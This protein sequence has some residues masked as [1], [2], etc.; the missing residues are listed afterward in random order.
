MKKVKIYA[1]VS[2]RGH[3]IS[4]QYSLEAFIEQV[5]RMVLEQKDFYDGYKPVVFVQ[6][7]DDE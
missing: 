1:M 7:K 6:E 2:E 4:M 5:S 3:A